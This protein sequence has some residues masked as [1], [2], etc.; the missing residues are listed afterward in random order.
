MREIQKYTLQERVDNLR[1][2]LSTRQAN[3]KEW[4]E[5]RKC[6]EMRK[7]WMEDYPEVFKEDLSKDDRIDMDPVVVD[8][9][10]NHEQVEVYHPK[11]C[12]EVPAYLKNAADKELKRMLEGG[13][14]EEAPGYSPIVSLGF[15]C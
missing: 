1:S 14:L 4:E 15:C 11:A 10:P 5:E 6:Q 12:S 13:L 7:A 8:L 2:K 3:K 9:I